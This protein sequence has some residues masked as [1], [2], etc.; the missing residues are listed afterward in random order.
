MA[1]QG[2]NYG[3]FELNRS[4]EMARWAVRSWQ[5]ST[6]ETRGAARVKVHYNAGCDLEQVGSIY[7]VTRR[8]NVIGIGSHFEV[9]IADAESNM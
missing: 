6:V 3:D 5:A 2:M 9:A 1:A 8:G 7:I 4:F